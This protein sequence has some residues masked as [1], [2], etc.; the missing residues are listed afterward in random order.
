MLLCVSLTAWCS[1]CRLFDSQYHSL[2]VDVHHECSTAS[3][4]VRELVVTHAVTAVLQLEPGAPQAEPWGI[5]TL[6]GR[7]LASLCPLAASTR[8]LVESVARNSGGAA[9]SST[10][11]DVVG[12][13]GSDT[14]GELEPEAMV[15]PHGVSLRRSEAVELELVSASGHGGLLGGPDA[16]DSPGGATRTSSWSTV[17]PVGSDAPLQLRVEPAVNVAATHPTAAAVPVTVSRYLSGSGLVQRGL[18]VEVRNA[19]TASE[20]GPLNVT[21]LDVVPAFMR[22]YLHTHTAT[23]RCDTGGV[24]GRWHAPD[25]PHVVVYRADPAELTGPPTVLSMLLSVPP[26]CALHLSMEYDLAFLPVE[27][28]PADPARGFDLPPATWWATGLDPAHLHAQYTTPLLVSLAVPAL[29]QPRCDAGATSCAVLALQV[30]VPTPD[31]T[32]PYNVITLTSSIATFF[33]GSMFNLLARK[34]RLGPAVQPEGA[35]GTRC[36]CAAIRV[37]ARGADARANTPSRYPLAYECAHDMPLVPTAPK[38]ST[39]R[40]CA[41]C[42]RKTSTN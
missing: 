20:P 12:R 23:L 6:F 11:S 31:F 21:V 16:S 29:P 28:Y 8:V 35:S 42:P 32:M 30:D 38:R 10:S 3:C 34:R 39:R 2:Q 14:D 1:R 9:P 22:P 24:V 19:G 25:C 5:D 27:A 18:N 40:R 17:V 41:R 7:Q 4:D 33:I 26:R 15:Q 13:S 37:L 36:G